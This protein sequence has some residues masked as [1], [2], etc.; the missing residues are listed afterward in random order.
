MSSFLY[1]LGQRCA[2]HPLRVVGVWLLIA[3][4]VLGLN[5][6]LGGSTKDNFTVP[7]VEAQRADRPAR[8]TASPSSPAHSGQIV[9][10]VDDGSVT[11]PQNA[12]SRSTL[13]LDRAP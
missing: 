2:R 11:D 13:A 5:N 12:D 9:F 1:R 6:Q 8:A 3:L 10:H 7:G 4:A